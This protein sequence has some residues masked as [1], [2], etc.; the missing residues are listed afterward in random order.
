MES[1]ESYC[2]RRT[3]E[4]QLAARMAS[5]AAARERH[6]EMADMY[7]LRAEMLAPRAR[8]DASGNPNAV[9]RPVQGEVCS[10]G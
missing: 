3:V 4:E 6:Q 2:R 8:D 9:S 1:D 10:P 7:R 5:C